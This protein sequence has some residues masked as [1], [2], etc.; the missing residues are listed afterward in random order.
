MTGARWELLATRNSVIDH[1]QQEAPSKPLSLTIR[2]KYQG[3][4]NKAFQGESEFVRSLDN[5]CREF[6][7]H[8]KI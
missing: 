1:S 6:V 8:N 5:A 3:L 2:S 4:V 7:N